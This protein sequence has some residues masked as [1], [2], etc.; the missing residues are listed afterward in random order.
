M[1]ALQHPGPHPRPHCGRAVEELPVLHQPPGRH[2]RRHP[3]G[4]RGRPGRSQATATT[5]RH[6]RNPA[7]NPPSARPPRSPTAAYPGTGLVIPHRRKR[8]QA[9]LPAWKEEHNKAHKQVRARV[10][11]VFARMKT[12]KILRDCRLKGDGVHHAM[13]ASPGC[14][15]S[16]SPDRRAGRTAACPAR[17]GLKIFY[18][19]ALKAT[20]ANASSR[21]SRAAAGSPSATRRAA[22]TRRRTASSSRW[23]AYT[24]RA[25]IVTDAT[26]ARD[27]RSAG[28]L[29]PLDRLAAPQPQNSPS[30]EEA[31][32]SQFRR[33]R[34][35]SIYP[36]TDAGIL[37]GRRPL[38]PLCSC[39]C[40]LAVTS[41]ESD[42][43][44]PRTP[45]SAPA[46]ARPHGYRFAIGVQRRQLRSDWPVRP[47]RRPTAGEGPR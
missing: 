27:R 25:V 30:K 2:R 23:T 47:G 26:P 31:P 28:I 15:T 44:S 7:P 13:L 11:H 14:T 20:A 5:A 19:T 33:E 8:G 18:G 43:E 1:L 6:G 24:V 41:D 32:G 37:L 29:D 42:R 22:S 21:T 40:D 46:P 34:A 4:R 3:P 9:E 35:L 16:P 39:S 38:R 17:G 36:I 10:E 45:A 12:W